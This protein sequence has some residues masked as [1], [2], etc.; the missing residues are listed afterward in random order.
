LL[1]VFV[2]NFCLTILAIFDQSS[3][4][5]WEMGGGGRDWGGGKR[6]WVDLYETLPAFYFGTPPPPPP[7]AP[8]VPKGGRGVTAAG[9]EQ[10]GECEG[11]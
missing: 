6:C 3:F 1:S 7:P 11:M 5:V 4:L 10:E 8:S 2:L 9:R